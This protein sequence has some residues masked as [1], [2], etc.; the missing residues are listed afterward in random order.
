MF[1]KKT[2]LSLLKEKKHSFIELAKKN[3]IPR[4]KNKE[5]GNFLF[6]L[7]KSGEIFKDRQDNYYV[8]KYFGEFQGIISINSKGFGFV[9]FPEKNSDL[10]ASIFV[11][12]FDLNGAFNGD[13]VSVKAF[14]ENTTPRRCF[15]TITKIIARNTKFLVGWTYF[16]KGEM[17][18]KAFNEKY[19]V[20]NFSFSKNVSNLAENKILKVKILEFHKSYAIVEIVKIIG[21]LNNP[22]DEIQLV[23]E[24]ANIITEFNHETLKES[25]K[26]PEDISE[27]KEEIK[28][29]KDFRDKLIVTIDGDDTKDFDDAISVEKKD[30]NFILNVHIADVSYYVKENSAIDLEAI[31]RGTSI[32]LVDRVIPMLPESLSNGICSLNPNVDRFTMA[33]KMEIDN[34][35]KTIKSEIFPSIINSKKRLTYKEVNDFYSK[36]LDFNEITG[37]NK[38]L[39]DALKLSNIL[40]KYKEKEGYVDFEIEESK[41]SLDKEGKVKS[42][43][44]RER[45]LSEILIENFM[46]RANEEVATFL[47]K[48]KIPTLYRIHD[49]P[50]DEKITKLNNVTK[51]LELPV[52][53]DSSSDSIKFSKSLINLK[54]QRFDNFIKIMILRTMQKAKYSPINIGHFGLGSKFYLHFTSPIRRYPDLLTH[55]IIREILFNKKN[56]KISKFNSILKKIGEMNSESENK[57]VDLERTVAD[58]KKA[59]FYENKI[60]QKFEGIIASILPFGFFVEFENKVDVLVHKDNLMDEYK[61]SEDETK[62]SSKSNSFIVGQKVYVTIIGTNRLARKIDAV[63]SQEYDQWKKINNVN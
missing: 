53:F 14:C 20:T 34:L 28:N 11:N 42:I 8:P 41:I 47:A 56:E 9:D 45:G 13:S 36:N 27:E 18:F 40:Q 29:R 33:I 52:K 51:S 63:L 62:L 50:S 43:D 37:L 48:N 46:I 30:E 15:G 31:E 49:K 22:F 61:L 6:S 54:S 38:M 5:F 39:E 4:F 2:I 19:N 26:I 23:I 16:A 21:E 59:E 60:G 58:I 12:K 57:A 35:G 55:R 10:G 17:K 44:I 7:V 1:D 3:K 32:Y 25:Q 24:D